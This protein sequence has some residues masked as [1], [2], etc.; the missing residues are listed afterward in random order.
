MILVIGTFAGVS[1]FLGGVLAHLPASLAASLLAVSVVGAGMLAAVSP[2]G[3]LVLSLCVPLVAAG[4][5]YDEWATSTG[6]MLLLVA[7]SAY[8]WLVSL[9][10]RSA[11]SRTG[12]SSRSRPS[13][14][15][16]GTGYGSASPRRSPT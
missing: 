6:T 1:M 2:G 16:R 14:Q 13:V 4:L 10:G 8:A 3:R 11:R 5:S 12:R 15:W 9:D 7:G